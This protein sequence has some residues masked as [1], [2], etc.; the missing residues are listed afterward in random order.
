MT[1]KQLIAISEDPKQFLLSG[2][3]IKDL[4]AAKKDR[5]LDWKLRAESITAPM[6]DRIDGGKN[7]CSYKE[8]TVAKAVESI[9]DLQN[10]IQDEILEL[11][12]TEKEIGK[13]ISALV[14]DH[15]HRTVLEMRYLNGYSERAISFKLSY[16]ED[17][18]YRL[19]TAALAS[20]QNEA[21]KKLKNI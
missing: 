10:E 9:V 18:I 11:M 12:H 13:A 19:H 15:R 4:I 21:K 3:H 7:S 20:M 1:T 14:S 16:G 17:W 6:G 5:I 2:K 8:S